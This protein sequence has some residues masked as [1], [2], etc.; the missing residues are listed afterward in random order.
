MKFKMLMCYIWVFADIIIYVQI[1]CIFHIR[2]PF[3]HYTFINSFPHGQNGR[4]FADDIFRGIFLSENVCNL[5]KISLKFVLKGPIDNN[6]AL[7]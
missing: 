2:Y 1:L 3:P 7:V 4:H 5:I 6:Q